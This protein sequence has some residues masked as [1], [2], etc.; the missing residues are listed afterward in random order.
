MTLTEEFRTLLQALLVEVQA[1][2]QQMPE[3]VLCGQGHDEDWASDVGMAIYNHLVA[4]ALLDRTPV[5]PP[6]LRVTAGE[7]RQLRLVSQIAPSIGRWKEA[8]CSVLNH[9]LQVLE[10]KLREMLEYLDTPQPSEAS[11]RKAQ[12]NRTSHATAPILKGG[13]TRPRRSR[14]KKNLKPSERRADTVAKIIQELNRLRP[15]MTGVESDYEALRKENPH[16]LT[17]KVASRFTDLKTKVLN[18]QDHRRHIRLAQELAAANHGRKLTTVQTDWKR[19][20]P[21]KYRQHV[22]K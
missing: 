13:R 18:V 9:D 11:A 5:D 8:D 16:F 12:D 3:D 10:S 15:R 21:D 1:L 2:L 19:H 17:F 22:H 20:K 7:L 14:I 4:Q 6:Q